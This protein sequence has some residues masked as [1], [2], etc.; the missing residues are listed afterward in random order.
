MMDKILMKEIG[1]RLRNERLRLKL[2]QGYMAEKIDVSLTFY[3]DIE[4][5]KKGMSAETLYKLKTSLGINIDYLL[6][7]DTTGTTKN[8]FEKLNKISP[9]KAKYFEQ[10]INLLFEMEK[11]D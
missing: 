11:D 6:T 1:E 8:I 4:R 5:G 3:G 2:N 9:Q 7:G 10:I